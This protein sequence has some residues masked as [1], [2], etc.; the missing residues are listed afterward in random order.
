MNI[1]AR[2]TNGIILSKNEIIKFTD[3]KTNKN[4]FVIG[5]A[6]SGKTRNF[7]LPNLMQ[8]NSCYV[9]SDNCG[10]ILSDVGKLLAEKGNYKIKIFNLSNYKESMHYNPFSY[11]HTEKDILELADIIIA[12]TEPADDFYCKAAYL[13]YTAF[14]G[15]IYY[16]CHKKEQNFN[17]LISMIDASEIQED[18]EEFKNSI[19]ILFEQLEQKKPNHFAVKQYKKYKLLTGKTIKSILISCATRLTVF[20]DKE[21]QELMSYDELELDIIG[22]NAK[23]DKTALFITFPTSW[24]DMKLITAMLYT[25][26]F[27]VLNDRANDVF[28]GE[29]PIPVHFLL[30]DFSFIGRIPNFDKIIAT[31]KGRNI[32]V[33]I[34]VQ[35]IS[36]IKGLY[37]KHYEEIIRNC[38]NMLYLG[39]MDN[40]TQEFIH[41][42]LNIKNRTDL[43]TGSVCLVAR[44]RAYRFCS[45]YD[46]TKH[47]LYRHLVNKA[48][49]I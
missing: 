8:M 41:K 40:E 24:S 42:Y 46:I 48:R 16:E 19:D 34:I 3:T 44:N 2:K 6:G 17:T 35:S 15:Y 9:V 18:D 20:R 43:R 28:G 13:L 1:K 37:G 11:I 45:Q 49:R 29:L 26:I 22:D 27:R 12:N 36:K 25:Q 21:L 30:D 39:A 33:S 32:W 4:T 47:K 14:I 5:G 7:V 23:D 10:L 38:D 31:L